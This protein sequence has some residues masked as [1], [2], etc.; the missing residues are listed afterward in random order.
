MVTSARRAIVRS[1]L[2]LR[3]TLLP[4]VLG[5]RYHR[6]AE[7]PNASAEQAARPAKAT[8]APIAAV[9]A[10]RLLRWKS[11]RPSR[12]KKSCRGRQPLGNALHV[13]AEQ[14]LRLAARFFLSSARATAQQ[15]SSCG[16]RARGGPPF[17]TFAECTRGGRPAPAA[18]PLA[19]R[20]K[21]TH[22][23]NE[24]PPRFRDSRV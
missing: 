18:I 13:P 8:S 6:T 9:F 15:R 10:S 1:G 12:R 21:A 19:C 16:R 7:R 24:S 23:L 20:H 17:S 5:P 2:P 14:S 4:A 11:E 22:Q 3:S